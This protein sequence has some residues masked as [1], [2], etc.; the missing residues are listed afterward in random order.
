MYSFCVEVF[1]KTINRTEMIDPSF[2]RKFY[3]A[4]YR[5]YKILCA[6]S[7]TRE[8]RSKF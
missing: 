3:G 4:C 7:I 1:E 2:E 8:A 6:N 5:L